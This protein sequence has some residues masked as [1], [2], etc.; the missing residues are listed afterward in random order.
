M[1]LCWKVFRLATRNS[2]KAQTANHIDTRAINQTEHPVILTQS[3]LPKIHSQHCLIQSMQTLPTSILHFGKIWSRA[4]QTQA[5]P[6]HRL[7]NCLASKVLCLASISTTNNSPRNNSFHRKKDLKNRIVIII[8]A[9]IGPNLGESL[10]HFYILRA[11][12][13]LLFNMFGPCTLLRVFYHAQ[14]TI[15]MI[16]RRLVGQL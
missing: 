13:L 3:T 9:T 11:F 5:I 14:C 7:S 16:Y 10:L 15:F 12:C 1:Y 8:I 6:V 2:I 4:I